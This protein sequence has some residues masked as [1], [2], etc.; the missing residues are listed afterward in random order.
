MTRVGGDDASGFV[1]SG[2]P[3]WLYRGVK[4]GRGCWRLRETLLE[5]SAASC[6]ESRRPDLGR[7][8]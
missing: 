6:V 3:G 4:Q 7:D 1:F 8:F 2:G 5:V